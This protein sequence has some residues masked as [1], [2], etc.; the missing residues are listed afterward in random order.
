MQGEVPE[1]GVFGGSN[2]RCGK[3]TRRLNFPPRTFYGDTQAETKSDTYDVSIAKLAIIGAESRALTIRGISYGGGQT[4]VAVL[5]LHL[6]S[7]GL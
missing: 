5:Q 6:D 1:K 7:N 2:C 3:C 4:L